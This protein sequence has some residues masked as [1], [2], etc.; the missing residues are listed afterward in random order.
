MFNICL[1]TRRGTK[2]FPRNVSFFCFT[3]TRAAGLE[4]AI[5]ETI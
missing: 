4:A 3:D 5:G 2:F 1:D